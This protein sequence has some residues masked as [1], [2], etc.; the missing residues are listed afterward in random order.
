MCTY[1]FYWKSLKRNI[2]EKGGGKP[3]MYHAKN[4]AWRHGEAGLAFKPILSQVFRRF[5]Q[6]RTG[7]CSSGGAPWKRRLPLVLHSL[8]PDKILSFP[9]HP[10]HL[11]FRG[12][13][14]NKYNYRRT[15]SGRSGVLKLQCLVLMICGEF[16][17]KKFLAEEGITARELEVGMSHPNEREREREGKKRGGRKSYSQRK[18]V[19]VQP[20]VRSVFNKA[21]QS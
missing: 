10:A 5:G 19:A 21:S 6:R 11:V 18:Y 15:L 8:L 13:D 20:D 3:L 9:S 4:I 17:F 12:K 7:I 16:S 14:I 2:A 1:K